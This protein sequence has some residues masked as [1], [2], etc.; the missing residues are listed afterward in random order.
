LLE[1]LVLP[2][3]SGKCND[4]YNG[5][6]FFLLVSNCVLYYGLKKLGSFSC[7]SHFV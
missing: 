1:T 6:V 3:G 7:F 2:F 5:H 4:D